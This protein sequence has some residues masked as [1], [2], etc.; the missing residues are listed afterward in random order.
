MAPGA[1]RRCWCSSSSAREAQH[2]RT[3]SHR[4]GVSDTRDG[5]TSA[6][7]EHQT[8]GAVDDG[9]WLARSIGGMGA[10]IKADVSRGLR[11]A[12]ARRWLFTSL[13]AHT[14]F[15]ARVDGTATV[16]PAPPSHAVMVPGGGGSDRTHSRRVL[17]P[18][19][20]GGTYHAL[21]PRSWYEHDPSALRPRGP[22]SAV[23]DV[24]S[25]R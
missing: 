11:E 21:Y 23:A 3:S 12:H 22:G 5:R 2:P 10:G 9:P 1:S 17:P 14:L 8:E 25:R 24:S 13:A 19:G 4:L 6:A 15:A 20:T 18:D 16:L 7:S